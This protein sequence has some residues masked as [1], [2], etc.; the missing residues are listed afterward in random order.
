M[1]QLA[2]RIFM[3]LAIY[4]NGGLGCGMG[5]IF[6]MCEFINKSKL[7]PCVYS[8]DDDRF[9]PGHLK[10]QNPTLI[11][12]KYD[13]LKI[14]ADVLLMDSFDLDIDEKILAKLRKRF[15]TILVDDENLL[16]RYDVDAVINTNIY[17]KSLPYKGVNTRFFFAPFFLRD[18]FLRPK[19]IIKEK[20]SNLVL[21]LGGSDDLN[22]SAL[23]AKALLPTLK[24]QNI[25]LHVISGPAFINDLSSLE[26]AN[27]CVHKEPK[28]GDL[29][30]CMDAGICAFGQS[31]YEFFALGVPILGISVASNQDKLLAYSKSYKLAITSSINNI[32]KD[33][34]LLDYPTKKMLCKNV[35]AHFNVSKDF[36]QNEFAKLLDF[37]KA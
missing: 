13:L 27:I 4:T 10:L 8:I 20:I 1:I 29:L 6:R 32:A 5:H 33:F 30:S 37:I 12:N 18:E 25:L 22:N 21:T 28:M 3:K 9:S 2:R 11:K 7:K 34:L 19:I 35:Q 23:I 16:A 17:A 36:L 15:K 14:K 31:A 24:A 26:C